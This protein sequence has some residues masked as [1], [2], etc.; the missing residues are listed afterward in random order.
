[1]RK[2]GLYVHWD[3]LAARSPKTSDLKKLGSNIA[4]SHAHIARMHKG[5]I[6]EAV[7]KLFQDALN[8]KKHSFVKE[9]FGISD[10]GP[11]IIV[12]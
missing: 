7:A 8:D 10:G 3:A 11:I 6:R 9:D 5:Y 1:M 2:G 12:P 4:A